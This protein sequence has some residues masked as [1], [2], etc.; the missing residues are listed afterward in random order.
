MPG[1]P[2]AIFVIDVGHENIAILEAK[3]LGIPVI[4]VVDTNNSPDNI[5]YIVPGNDDSMGAVKLYASHI[6]EA[7]EHGRANVAEL[8]GD[9]EEL[10][11]VDE[12]GAPSKKRAAPKKKVVAKKKAAPKK[13]APKEAAA[14]PKPEAAEAPKAEAK[15]APAEAEEAA[16]AAAEAEAPAA[17]AAPEEAK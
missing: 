2:D 6:A 17:E 11:E 5:D 14:E 7:I 13:A 15:A 10:I 1:L 16:P 12:D 4:G 3:K 9:G 8:A